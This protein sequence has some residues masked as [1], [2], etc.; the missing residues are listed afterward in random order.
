MTQKKSAPL[1]MAPTANAQASRR[2]DP[3]LA[4]LHNAQTV[5]DQQRACNGPAFRGI[6]GDTRVEAR[7]REAMAKAK[8]TPNAGYGTDIP[9]DGSEHGFFVGR[10]PLFGAVTSSIFSS[11]REDSMAFDSAREPHL[12]SD[13]TAV[14]VHQSPRTLPGL[15]QKDIN[16]TY[17]SPK[18]LGVNVVAVDRDGRRYC[19]VRQ[20]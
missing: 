16:L 1:S 12:A 17:P 14:H 15:S 8:A 9:E 2:L 20:K 5:L 4:A 11:D 13:M 6:L 10:R 18:G 19:R 3:V 7:I